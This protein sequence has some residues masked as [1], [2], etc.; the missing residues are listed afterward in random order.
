MRTVGKF[1]WKAQVPTLQQFAGDAYLNDGRAN[2]IEAAITAHDGQG[3]AARDRF[4]ALE[5]RDRN[6]L[7]AFLRSL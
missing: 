7:L 2:S 5:A 4:I 1:G 3:R 6:R